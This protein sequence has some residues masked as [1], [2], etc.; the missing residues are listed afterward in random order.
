MV[1]VCAG[2]MDVFGQVHCGVQRTR[3]GTVW[4]CAHYKDEAA[5]LE[6][7]NREAPQTPCSET[8]D[9][10]RQ[11]DCRM[12]SGRHGSRYT[13]RGWSERTWT[14]SACRVRHECRWWESGGG[15]LFFLQAVKADKKAHVGPQKQSQP[16]VS[17]RRSSESFVAAVWE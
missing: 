11:Q 10:D 7:A 3:P 9:A 2:G 5:P 6:G 13:S 14:L 8:Q 4:Y 1:V 17:S 16:R 15:V 12:Q